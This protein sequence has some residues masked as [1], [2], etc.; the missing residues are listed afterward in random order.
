MALLEE[1]IAY[2]KEFA[3]DGLDLTVVRAVEFA[4]VFPSEAEAEAFA[5]AAAGDGVDVDVLEPE[6]E[7]DPW[8]VAVTIELVPTAGAITDIEIR[9]ETLAQGFNGESD[10]WGLYDDE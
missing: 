6:D 3:S 7:V 8:E 10:G 5:K 9:L 1:N 4:H 2:L